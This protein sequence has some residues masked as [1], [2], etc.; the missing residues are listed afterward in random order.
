[1]CA[2]LFCFKLLIYLPYNVKYSIY[3]ADLW[4]ALSLRCSQQHARSRYGV[5][6]TS[7]AVTEVAQYITDHYYYR[8]H[9]TAL[10][11]Q[12]RRS[13]SVFFFAVVAV[14]I[15]LIRVR[16]CDPP[17]FGLVRI[18]R[19]KNNIQRIRICSSY[20]TFGRV[21]HRTHEYS[22]GWQLRQCN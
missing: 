2:A 1:M 22:L 3:V 19:T 7:F 9:C 13:A 10:P 15:G 8:S 20:I 17:V 4:H 14:L 21:V 5:Q 12:W 11:G 16:A 18:W 6:C